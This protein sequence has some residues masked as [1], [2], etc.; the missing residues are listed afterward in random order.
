[1]LTLEDLGLSEPEIQLYRMCLSRP[2]VT[3]EQIQ[4][5]QVC[6]A[7]EVTEMLA[8][9]ARRRVIARDGDTISA[10]A[11]AELVQRLV[12]DRSHWLQQQSYAL[13][14]CQQLIE[15]LEQIRDCPSPSNTNQ[16]EI[17]A[18]PSSVQR[19]SED[20][21]FFARDE[22]LSIEPSV[23]FDAHST[24]FARPL[25]MMALRRKVSLRCIFA[26]RV[27]PDQSG[28]AYITEIANAGARVVLHRSPRVRVLVFDRKAA[29]VATGTESTERFDSALLVR[30]PELLSSLIVMFE[31]T[32]DS[33]KAFKPGATSALEPSQRETDVLR[34][35]CRAAKDEVAAANLCVST[36]TYR[37]HVAELVHRLGAKTRTEAALIARDRGWI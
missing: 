1:M 31:L 28:V 16:V 9:L 6:A 23:E 17:L 18:D 21:A 35:M 7:V 27:T 14:R 33:A 11:P 12:T 25:E 3:E 19:C 34:E 29:L 22:I 15:E 32:W 2:G 8:D 26:D 5:A 24:R 36:R 4:Q 20:L 37:R 13:T 10:C 30:D